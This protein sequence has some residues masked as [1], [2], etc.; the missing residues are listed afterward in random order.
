MQEE[1]HSY[2]GIN[3]LQE[4]TVIINL[5]ESQKSII[6]SFSLLNFLARMS[7][8]KQTFGVEKMKSM[9]ERVYIALYDTFHGLGW[10]EMCVVPCHL[11]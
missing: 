4:T 10:E 8:W 1:Q 7:M 3:I 6:S 9:V 11:S 5:G 2:Q